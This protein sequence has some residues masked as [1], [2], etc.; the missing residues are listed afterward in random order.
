MNKQMILQ[1]LN[2]PC[3]V[4]QKTNELIDECIQEVKE[5]AYFKTTSQIF[6]LTHQPLKIE[7]LNLKLNS[8]DLEE[9]FDNCQQVMIVGCTLGVNI[10][11]QIKYYEKIDMAKAVVFDAV[12]SRY[13]E[14]CQDAYEKEH[15]T[16]I[17]TFRFAPGYGDLPI[18]H[19]I[20]LSHVLKMDKVLGVSINQGGLFVPMKSMLGLIGIGAK[21]EKSCFSCVRKENCQLRKV[22]LRCYAID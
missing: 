17:H 14:E 7:E 15:I 22:G 20:P 1:Y 12:S 18:E 9:Y 19:N 6:S 13:L 10:D 16:D 5:L 4:D 11:R 2:C 21:K 8:Q 3:E